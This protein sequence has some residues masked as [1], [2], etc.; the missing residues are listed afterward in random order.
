MPMC[1]CRCEACGKQ[2]GGVSVVYLTL[3]EHENR[4]INC[5]ACGSTKMQQ[6]YSPF[7]AHT[8]KKS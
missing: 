3:A 7:Y 2:V 5:P 6:I 1:D 8:S 4:K